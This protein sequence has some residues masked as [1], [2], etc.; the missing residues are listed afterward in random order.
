MKLPARSLIKK[1]IR[2][3][4]PPNTRLSK[5]ADLYVMLAFL[6]YMQRLA[7]ESRVAHQIDLSN[8]LKGSRSITRRHLNGAR[9]RVR[10]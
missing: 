2:A 7:N 3:H 9:K 6:I 4:L 8:G 5:T 10:G 1:L